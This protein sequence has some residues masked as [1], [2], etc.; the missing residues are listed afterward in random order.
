MMGMES[1]AVP[2]VWCL[3]YSRNP[4]WNARNLAVLRPLLRGLLV[5]GAVTVAMA[6]GARLVPSLARIADRAAEPLPGR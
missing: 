4:G 1:T 2:F 5:A 6:A 3:F